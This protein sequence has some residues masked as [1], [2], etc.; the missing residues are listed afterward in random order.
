M[1][2]DPAHALTFRG[3]VAQ[4]G[5][6][7][8]LGEVPAAEAGLLGERRRR[9]LAGDPG[10]VV[11]HQAQGGRPVRRL[12]GAHPLALDPGR[13]ARV[14]GR[15]H[16]QQRIGSLDLVCSDRR[17]PGEQL[18]RRVLEPAERRGQEALERDAQQCVRSAPGDGR[19]DFLEQRARLRVAADEHLPAGLHAEAAVDDQL[20]VLAVARVSH[21]R[22]TLTQ[23][24]A[25]LA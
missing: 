23:A 8:Q 6:V 22:F 18:E 15:G 7:Q 14:V 17:G 9:V 3:P 1:R 21:C 25:R 13:R 10:D 20:R 19:A 5:A 16:E 4:H 12:Q 24:R 11:I 2:R